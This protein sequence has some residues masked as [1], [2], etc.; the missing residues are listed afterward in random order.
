MYSMKE[1]RYKFLHTFLMIILTIIIFAG[2]YLHIAKDSNFELKVYV[3]I[4]FIA[5][6]TFASYFKIKFDRMYSVVLDGEQLSITR[7]SGW[8]SEE[9]KI[10]LEDITLIR[11]YRKYFIIKKIEICTRY[12]N[13]SLNIKNFKNN[14]EMLK[15][16]VEKTNKNKNIRNI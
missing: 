14:K 2:S 8:V 4:I 3:A 13:V 15:T 6:L 5:S 11:Y 9:I 16:V 1:Y 10:L 12:K 7:N